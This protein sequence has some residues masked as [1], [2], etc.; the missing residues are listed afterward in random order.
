MFILEIQV[1]IKLKNGKVSKV[2]YGMKFKLNVSP[3][4]LVIIRVWAHVWEGLI[5]R[6]ERDQLSRPE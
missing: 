4:V 1:S 2:I 5:D 6:V 3:P